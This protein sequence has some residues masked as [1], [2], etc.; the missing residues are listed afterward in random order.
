[1]GNRNSLRFY[2]VLL[3]A[4]V[5]I[6]IVITIVVLRVQGRQFE[7]YTAIEN[8]YHGESIR[9]CME[10]KEE[11]RR[12]REYLIVEN[13]TNGSIP[14]ADNHAGDPLDIFTSHHTFNLSTS[15]HVVHQKVESIAELQHQYENPKFNA[16]ISNITKEENRLLQIQKEAR[17]DDAS[18]LVAVARSVT[19]FFYAVQQLQILHE[20][21][22][23]VSEDE[24]VAAQSRS[25]LFVILFSLIALAIVGIAIRKIIQSLGQALRSKEEAEKGK[26]LLEERIEESEKIGSLGVLASGIAHDFNNILQIIFANTSLAMAD[27]PEDSKNYVY[28]DQILD[29]AERA[30][31]LVMQ[32]L[33]FS[34]GT[35]G[36]HVPLLI[37]NAV[38]DALELIRA[39]IPATVELRKD[40]QFD[41]GV[42]LSD[43]TEIHQI[44]MNLCTNAHH[45]M[46]PDGGILTVTLTSEFLRLE[47]TQYHARL[48]P[49]RYAHLTVR[50]T[51]KGIPQELVS[52]VFEPFFTTKDAGKG[53]GLGLSL[54]HGIIRQHQGDITIESTEGV[55]TTVHVYLPLTESKPI[56]EEEELRVENGQGEHILVVDDEEPITKAIE[57]ILSSSGYRVSAMSNSRQAFSSFESGPDDYDLILTDM[58]M[59][60]LTGEELASKIKTIRPKIPI[61][62][63]S[64]LSDIM[65]SEINR[66]N[67]DVTLSKPVRRAELNLAIRRALRP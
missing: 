64:G 6:L 29:G 24:I 54:I 61:I 8:E 39:T 34:R 56:E 5:A 51:G 1:M 45:A 14:E 31:T 9:L 67:F 22:M 27:M 37:D 60:Y 4:L 11:L 53:T 33:T 50:D 16:I 63:M 36:S 40:I 25:T 2:E 30:K 44:V 48:K 46:S 19:S 32:I 62:L 20:Q 35:E 55:G 49:G 3:F 12:V 21:E 28:M 38:N 41:C 10:V 26:H 23:R 18:G 59:P 17:T 7:T 13:L 52:R 43:P 65:D 66:K 47:E 15:L 58:T 57:A 42:V